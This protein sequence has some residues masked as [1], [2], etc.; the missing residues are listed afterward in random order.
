MIE[1]NWAPINSSEFVWD[2]TTENVSSITST[3]DSNY[4][5][6][7]N[8]W[9]VFNFY[10]ILYQQYWNYISSHNLDDLANKSISKYNTPLSNWW[11]IQNTRFDDIIFNID[12]T[13]T[14]NNLENLEKE[15]SDIKRMFNSQIKL[16]KNTNNK[17]SY[18]D[19]VLTDFQVWDVLISWT[20]INLSFISLNPFWK[21]WNWITKFFEGINW[22]LN[23]S[24]IINDSD[25]SV[26]LTTIIQLKTI[27]DDITSLTIEL[28]WYSITF[29]H[30]C[31][32]NDIIIYDGN[33]DKLF[34]NWNETRF[35]WNFLPFPILTPWSVK[36]SY[37][38]WWSIDLYN[39]YILYDKIIL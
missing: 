26:N 11:I 36:L 8:L 28:N 25:Y 3:I 24:L 6:I 16:Y 9:L 20:N 31:L 34:I 23:T 10:T 5:I 37:T 33:L 27:S 15:I 7:S 32:E 1:I 4:A 2:I 17:E 12:L 13:L 14:S 30:T 35:K 21:E 22:P 29:N 39:M 19:I 38:W 18:I